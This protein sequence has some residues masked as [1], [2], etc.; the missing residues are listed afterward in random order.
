MLLA[1]IS[2]DPVIVV[3][4]GITYERIVL[5][6]WMKE[7]GE[8][9]KTCPTTRVPNLALKSLI[10]KAKENFIHLQSKPTNEMKMD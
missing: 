1:M 3:P 2:V 7:R 6:E 5:D 4:S 8:N 10:S 9:G